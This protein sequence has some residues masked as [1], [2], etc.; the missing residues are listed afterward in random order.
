MAN[1]AAKVS[2]SPNQLTY[3][4][5]SDGSQAG[6][7]IA[8]ATILADM[9][10]GP[11]RDAWNAVLTTQAAMRNSLLGGL[12]AIGGGSCYAIVQLLTT[13]KDVTAEINQVTVD[14]DTDAVSTT[15]AEINIGMSDTT[16]QIAMLHLIH[17]HSLT[18]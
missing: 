14:V 11:L 6:P 16:G 5:T 10:R 8:N 1:T 17:K 9:V 12:P 3:L 13:G 15:K 2:A 4:L 18:E 7:T